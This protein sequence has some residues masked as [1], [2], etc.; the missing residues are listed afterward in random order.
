MWSHPGDAGERR[1]AA[2]RLRLHDRRARQRPARLGP[3]R[4]RAA[5]PSCRG[6]STPSSRPWATRR[7]GP[8]TRPPARRSSSRAREP[9]LAGRHVVISAGGTRRADRPG[10]VHRQ[11]LDRQDGR[12]PRR[13]PR[14][15]AARGSRSSSPP[16]SAVALAGRCAGRPR[17]DDRP[18]AGRGPLDPRRRRR[19]ALIM[20][21]AVA[22]FR[23]RR[24]A[25]KKL[26]RD[27]GLTHRARADRGHP[28]RRIGRRPGTGARRPR[29]ILVGF[30]AE[31][32]SLER[33]AEKLR[34]KGVDL[35]VAN[36]VAEAGSG[37][38]TD[39]NRVTILAAD[40]PRAGAAAALEAGGRRP[41][42]RP[43]RRRAGR[44]RRLD[45]D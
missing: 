11:P 42:P 31:T 17:R 10:P 9:D 27:E 22:D 6:S 36:D 7:S 37:F 24:P 28:R 34:R 8:R 14:W 44:S 3:V 16:T 40:G 20:A 5:S 32:G 25:T 26:S 45:A 19:D 30:A 39:T 41:D 23:P 33:A 35:L 21:A 4:R 1:P 43:G 15:T 18:D 29:P 38:G 2:R 13:R 12:R